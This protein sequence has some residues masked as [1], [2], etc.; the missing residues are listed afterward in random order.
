M[1]DTSQLCRFRAMKRPRRSFI[2]AQSF[3]HAGRSYTGIIDAAHESGCIK[4][5]GRIE[6]LPKGTVL[7]F[8]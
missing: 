4:G 3:H 1:P 5:A 2:R 8:K 7:L 6:V